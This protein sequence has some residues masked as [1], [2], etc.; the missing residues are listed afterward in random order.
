MTSADLSGKTSV[1]EG[2]DDISRSTVRKKNL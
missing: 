1:A 2:L